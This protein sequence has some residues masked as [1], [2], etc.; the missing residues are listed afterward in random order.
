[1]HVWSCYKKHNSTIGDMDCWFGKYA[2]WWYTTR[3]GIRWNP[4]FEFRYE[5]QFVARLAWVLLMCR[6]RGVS[7][8]IA[9]YAG[10][11]CYESVKPYVHFYGPFMFVV[12]LLSLS[13]FSLLFS[14][15]FFFSQRECP[16]RQELPFYRQGRSTWSRCERYGR[17]RANIWS[18]SGDLM[19]FTV[20]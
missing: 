19:L 18:S 20:E 9:I 5:D 6:E 7:L 3:A 16:F 14:F 11:H 12:L 17:R 1:M 4:F 8:E 13:F 2:W 15:L 10:S